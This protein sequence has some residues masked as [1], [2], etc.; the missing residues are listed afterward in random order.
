MHTKMPREN[1]QIMKM[2]KEDSV[3]DIR[4]WQ[5]LWLIGSTSSIQRAAATQSQPIN[6]NNINYE[7]LYLW[8]L[9]ASNNLY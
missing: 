6:F 8:F 4:E 1:K 3:W 9:K 7:L 2:N 5:G